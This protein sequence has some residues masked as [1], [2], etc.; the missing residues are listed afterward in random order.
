MK[1]NINWGI[2]G[3][4][5]IALQFA[6][7]FRD[8]KNGKLKA[9]SSKNLNKIKLF[10]DKFNVNKKYCFIEYENL[11]KCE[12]VDIVYIALPNSMHVE[13]IKKSIMVA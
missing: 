12:D 5:T 1:Q 11:L 2:I 9:I 3:L 10:S 8:S 7:A 4:G 13:W 6:Q